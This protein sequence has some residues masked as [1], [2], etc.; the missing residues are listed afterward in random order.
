LVSRNAATSR[1]HSWA[2]RGL[3]GAA[4]ASHAMPRHA[5]SSN[6]VVT[7]FEHG[8]V[9]VRREVRVEPRPAGEVRDHVVDESGSMAALHVSR[10]NSHQPAWVEQHDRQ[11]HHQP[12]HHGREERPQP[13]VHPAGPDAQQQHRQQEERGTARRGTQAEQY[14]ASAVFAGTRPTARSRRTRWR[15]V[16]VGER[17]HDDQRPTRRP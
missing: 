12:R 17:L 16:E 6:V 15:A 10:K 3:R 9:L 7:M 2:S 11:V 4:S 14:P 5:S 1:K 13:R 8:R